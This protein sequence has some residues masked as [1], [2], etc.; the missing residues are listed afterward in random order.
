MFRV[1]RV[2]LHLRNDVRRI[3]PSEARLYPGSIEIFR[4]RRRRRRRRR[5][6]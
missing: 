1:K 2:N 5:Q 6:W 3:I 4:S